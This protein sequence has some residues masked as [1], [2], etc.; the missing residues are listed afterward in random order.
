MLNV[1]LTRE[2][3]TTFYKQNTSTETLWKVSVKLR[4]FSDLSKVNTNKL[5]PENFAILE[6]ILCVVNALGKH[7]SG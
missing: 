4:K 6:N 5:G 7:G 2:L 1:F 3:F